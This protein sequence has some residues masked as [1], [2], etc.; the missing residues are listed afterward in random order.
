MESCQ[1]AYP[2]NNQI[3]QLILTDDF[4]QL[5]FSDSFQKGEK[6]KVLLQLWLAVS[7]KFLGQRFST[8]SDCH[9]KMNNFS[10]KFPVHHTSKSWNLG[11]IMEFQPNDL[12][13]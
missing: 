12:S 11:G 9:D 4:I 5:L 1:R 2:N 13:K 8:F 10:I 7:S 3:S 6:K